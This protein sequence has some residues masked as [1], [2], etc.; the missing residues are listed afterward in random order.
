[1]SEQNH[2][3]EFS[4]VQ[5]TGHE[6]D[7]I[8]ELDNPLPRWWQW[9]LWATVIWSVGYWFVYPAWPLISSHTT[10]F[11]GYSSRAELIDDVAAAKARQSGHLKKLAK[12]SL[13]QI[14]T[15]P[16]LLEFALA[17]GRSAYNVNCSQCHG[18]GAQGF[19]GFPNLNDDEW[20]WGGTLDQ[21]QYTITHG[22]R[23]DVDDD[24]H[25]SDMPAFL[26]DEILDTKEIA[27]VTQYVLKLSGQDHQSDEALSGAATFADECAAC[28][29]DDGSGDIDAG[30]PSLNNAI[31]L[32]GGSPESITKTISHSR[33]GVMPAWGPILDDVTVKQLAVYVHSLGGGQ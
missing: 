12:A 30:A 4:G 15:D 32:Y 5:T 2:V 11:I 16:E 24:A 1:M 18:S 20:L 21:I 6:W 31:W 29:S 23:N 26:D 25:Y 13:E 27:D 17:G 14:R 7:G 28:H 10:G 19:T 8:R 33:S 3:D 22:A 9:I